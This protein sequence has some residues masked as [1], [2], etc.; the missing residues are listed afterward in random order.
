M[1][2]KRIQKSIS[3]TYTKIIES[4]KFKFYLYCKESLT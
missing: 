1:Y 2:D 4:I 3:D